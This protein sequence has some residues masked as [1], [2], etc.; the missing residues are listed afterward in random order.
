MP[1]NLVNLADA[2]LERRI[3]A[4]IKRST[5]ECEAGNLAEATFAFCEVQSLI[6]ERSTEQVARMERDQGLST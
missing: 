1:D 2:R 6:S 3:A 5:D 4:A